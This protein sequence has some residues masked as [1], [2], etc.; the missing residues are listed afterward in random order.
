MICKK[1]IK[2]FIIYAIITIIIDILLFMLFLSVNKIIEYSLLQIFYLP[3]LLLM[4]GLHHDSL[5]EDCYNLH[6]TK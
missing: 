2:V 5:Y 4:Y 3:G 6:E 1:H